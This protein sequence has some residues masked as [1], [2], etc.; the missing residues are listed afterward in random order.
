MTADIHSIW[1]MPGAEDA[2]R[3]ARILGDLSRQFATPLFTPHLTVKGDSDAP[4][5]AL[6]AAIRKAARTVAPFSAPVVAIETSE[7]FF[8]SFYARFDVSTPLER[9]KQALDADATEPF[10]PH[11]SLLYG[12][13]AAAPKTVA[14]REAG[15]LL[16]D[17]AITFDRLCVVTSGQD[18]PI[19][20]WRIM[21]TAQLGSG[22][23]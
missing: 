20:D 16:V 4:L 12:P 3:L 2:Q 14:V 22:Q 11:V 17:R 13:V 21:A 23:A 1:L 18:V 6:D 19:A 10:M 15:C 9:L 8:R 7:L 5:A